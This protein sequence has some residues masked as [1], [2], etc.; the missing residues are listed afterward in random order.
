MQGVTTGVLRGLGDTRTAML[1]NVV[2]HWVIGL[3]VAAF[4]AFG[5]GWGVIGLW[6][7][8]SISLTL[9]GVV[10]IGVWRRRLVE[11]HARLERPLAPALRPRPEPS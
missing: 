8:L 2:G 9:V 4:M 10:L 1:A 7:G 3:P 5:V 11:L 6:A